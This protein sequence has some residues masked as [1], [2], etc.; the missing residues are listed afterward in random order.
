VLHG[1]LLALV[2][3]RCFQQ[4]GVLLRGRCFCGCWD[5]PRCVAGFRRGVR[6]GIGQVAAIVFDAETLA[7]ERLRLDTH[8]L[9][10]FGGGVRD[11]MVI[12]VRG[13]GSNAAHG[14]AQQ[15]ARRPFGEQGGGQHHAEAP[16]GIQCGG[17]QHRIAH[18]AQGEGPYARQ[19][20][21]HA[22]ERGQL[23]RKAA[24]PAGTLGDQ[25]GAHAIGGEGNRACG[26]RLGRGGGGRGLGEGFE[27]GFEG[28][29]F[30]RIVQQIDQ[31]PRFG[32]A[33]RRRGV[34]G[35]GGGCMG[36]GETRQG[37]LRGGAW[38]RH[39][40]GQRDN[41]NEEVHNSLRRL[42]SDE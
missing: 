41:G 32:G 1:G 30:L 27:I 33:E 4:R 8:I 26:F 10:A 37:Y 29:A 28:R 36:R 7:P 23:V 5:A 24:D 35:C 22:A 42:M 3:G 13:V 31:L 15:A 40:E 25:L 20:A 11:S 14:A 16:G 21:Q 19:V 18:R 9:G 2:R 38:C 12:G 34:G 17:A 6:F 39:D